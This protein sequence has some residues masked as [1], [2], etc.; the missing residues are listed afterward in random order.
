[1]DQKPSTKLPDAIEIKEESIKVE[2]KIQEPHIGSFIHEPTPA[3]V[4]AESVEIEEELDPEEKKDITLSLIFTMIGA[5][6]VIA[7]VGYYI[8]HFVEPSRTSVIPELLIDQSKIQTDTESE[9]LVME[10]SETASEELIRKYQEKQAV[11]KTIR[12]N[13]EL[14]ANQ[15]KT[16]TTSTSTGPNYV[17]TEK[18]IRATSTSNGATINRTQSLSLRATSTELGI[19]FLKDPYWKQTTKG[20]TTILQNVGP[21]AKDAI[22]MTRFSGAS[23]TTEDS[24]RGNVTYFYQS[25]NKT[26]MRIDYFGDLSTKE[27]ITPK[28]F[29]PIRFT[30]YKKPIL[31]GTSRSKTLVIAFSTND[32]LIINISGTGY[33][34]ILDAFAAE[35]DTTR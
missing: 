16:T 24:M 11:E 1:M 13:D 18:I 9:E 28:A 32:F 25:D 27:S 7:G 8:K 3:E 10:E 6:T 33:T 4:A 23:V 5:L 21:T 19:S 34:G 14:F 20:S 15:G 22:M 12:E 17:I 31:D 29:V 2:E 30:K 26:W 35:I